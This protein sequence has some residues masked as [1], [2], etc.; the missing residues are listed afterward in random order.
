MHKWTQDKSLRLRSLSIA[1]ALFAAQSVFSLAAHAQT[2]YSLTP[3]G[4][5]GGGTT[6]ANAINSVGDVVGCSLT[7]INGTVTN[8]AFVYRNGTITD[9][10]AL[11]ND[12]TAC[13]NDIND[14]GV[15]TGDSTT[16]TGEPRAF[17]YSNGT[18]TSLGNLGSTSAGNSINNAGLVAGTANNVNG[19]LV[20]SFRY[21]AQLSPPQ[22]DIGNLGGGIITQARSI[23]AA[24]DIAGWAVNAASRGTSFLYQN[25]VITDLGAVLGFPS[26]AM[27]INDLG[28]VIGQTQ[29]SGYLYD[30]GVVTPIPGLQ[31]NIS[32]PHA[33]NNNG[34]VVGASWA[35][36]DNHAFVYAQGQ[37]VD[38]NNLISPTSPDQPFVTLSDARGINDDG[39]IIATGVDSRTRVQGAYLLRPIP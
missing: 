27:A 7:V 17:V 2:T 13:A 6:E 37:S 15:I 20:A 5:L 31:A 25:G 9:I 11:V 24:G 23:N 39:W 10:G 29:D 1:A 33:L 14:A 4:S 30:N 16:A 34:Q 12:G 28:Q 18:M 8:R 22:V 21:D 32:S 19:I 26:Q 38:L 3:I 35:E 36:T